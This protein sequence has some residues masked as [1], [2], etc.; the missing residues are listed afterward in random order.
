M[1]HVSVIFC[2]IFALDLSFVSISMAK[3]TSENLQ[4]SL[5]T[6]KIT[7]KVTEKK[8]ERITSEISD[9]KMKVS[10]TKKTEEK[11]SS[12]EAKI[13]NEP[14]TKSEDETEAAKYFMLTSK[15]L[16]ENSASDFDGIFEA[17]RQNKVL[18]MDEALKIIRR[19]IIERRPDQHIDQYAVF[20]E[21]REVFSEAEFSTEELMILIE[22]ALEIKK[23][24]LLIFDFVIRSEYARRAVKEGVNAEEVL[25]FASS[26][27]IQLPKFI[28][29]KNINSDQLND[30]LSDLGCGVVWKDRAKYL[31]VVNKYFGEN[32]KFS[33][34]ADDSVEKFERLPRKVQNYL[35]LIAEVDKFFTK[36][37]NHLIFLIAQDFYYADVPQEKIMKIFSFADG[38]WAS[39]IKPNIYQ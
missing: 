36:A 29:R 6:K 34:V 7:E 2:M 14:K 5:S 9:Q 31:F 19:H 10:D 11:I 15:D 35:R 26:E 17:E 8:T 37:Y 23:K 38:E 39:L 3:E 30:V 18:G 33:G 20:S 4:A 1:R 32:A 27:Y 12:Q 24:Y 21:L 16:W 25:Q 28:L 22:D 13:S